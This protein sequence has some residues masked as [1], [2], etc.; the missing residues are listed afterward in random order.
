MA[1]I[2]GWH[3]FCGFA[4]AFSIIIAVNTTLAINAVRTFPGLETKNSYIASQSFEADRSAQLALEWE[5]SGSV[6]DGMLLLSIIENGQP[7]AP[8]I[9]SAIFGR[10]THVADDQSLNF[11]HNGTAF[12]APIEVNSG[13]WNLRI[14]LRAESGEIFSQRIPIRVHP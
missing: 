11:A 5:V 4:L 13:N 6:Q 14:R 10:A 3:V 2:K 12:E 9:E 8:I 1:E 7:I